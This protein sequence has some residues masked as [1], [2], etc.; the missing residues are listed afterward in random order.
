MIALG[1]LLEKDTLTKDMIDI[2][3]MAHALGSQI[4]FS[5]SAIQYNLNF[6]EDN[7]STMTKSMSDPPM[8]PS[9][10]VC[11]VSITLL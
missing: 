5:H 11:T 1:N 9:F 6:T 10:G 4:S 3:G 7:L 2:Y 8:C